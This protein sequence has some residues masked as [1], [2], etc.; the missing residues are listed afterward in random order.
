M[1]PVIEARGIVKL[2]RR[3]PETVRALRG[4]D[5]SLQEGELVALLGPSGSG[6]TTL[7]NVLSG[8][9]LPDEGVLLWQGG[10]HTALGTLPWHLLSVLPQ[11]LGLL[12]ELSVRENVELPLRLSGTLDSAGSERV[13]ELLEWLGLARLAERS[14][15]ETSLGEQQRTALARAILPIPR[16]LLADEPAGHQD[17]AFGDQVL[18][19]LRA[20]ARRGTAC[21]VATHNPESV[22]FCDRAVEMVDGR[23]EPFVSSPTLG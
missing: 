1:A 7:L 2:Y 12:E 23:V 15:T 20:A 6:K 9:E 4:A 10:N 18:R 19:A 11:R 16:L 22:R 8:W 14:P 3:G 17:R 13:S 5:L 21:L